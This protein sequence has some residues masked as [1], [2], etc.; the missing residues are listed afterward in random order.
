MDGLSIARERITREADEKT[1]SL[2]L[3]GL[4]LIE[5]PRELFGLQGLQRLNLG[6][7]YWD[8]EA[9]WQWTLPF[10]HNAIAAQI[11]HLAQL[12][13]LQYL[14]MSGTDLSD[15]TALKDLK[16]LQSIDC[17]RTQVSDLTPLKDL[18][19]LQSIDC[20]HTRVSDL[21]PLADLLSLQSLNCRDTQVSDL[22]PLKD[23]KNLQSINCSYTRVSSLT[24]LK[25]LSSLQSLDC[26]TARVGDLAPLK[27]L[28]SL[29]SL[30]FTRT[31]VS[32]L[33]PLKDL[34]SLRSVTC[35]VTQVS[36]LSPLKDLKSLRSVACSNTQVSDLSPLKDLKNLQSL[37]C[38]ATNVN[39]LT[40]LKD[41]KSL[42]LLD[43]LGTQVTSLTPLKGLK[44]LQSLDCSYTQI[45][46]LTPLKDVANLQSLYCSG[47]Q[48][49]DLT[50]LKDLASLE[51]LSCAGTQVSD[52]TPLKDLASLES[53]DCSGTQVNALTPLK[54]LASLQSLDCSRSQVKDLAP[55]KD[56]QSLL[57]LDCSGTQVNDLTPLTDLR[58]LQWLNCSRCRLDS[59][60]E[61]LLL[62]P[63]LTDLILYE[64]HLPRTPTEVLSQGQ[65]DNCLASLRAHLRDLEAG[66]EPMPD[67]KLMVLGNGRVG[68]TQMCRRLRNEA[69]DEGVESTHGILVTSAP[70]VPRSGA[71]HAERLQIWDFGGQDIYHGTHALFMRSRAIFALAWIPEAEKIAEHRHGG[72]VFRNQPLG[73][74]LEY[75]RH[76]GSSD[77]PVLVI[78]ARCDAPEDEHVRLPVADDALAAFRFRKVLHYSARRDRG[79]A[80]LDEVLRE[81]A[82]WLTE[83]KGIA[84]IGAG[85]S[86]VKRRLEAMRD[87]DAARGPLER[88]H[89]SISQ[90]EFRRLCDEAGG[91]ASP[92]HLLSYLHNAGAVF[93][94]EGLFGN[95]IILDQGWALEAIYAVFHREKCLRKLQRQNGRFTRSDLAEWIWDEAGYGD[96]EQELFLSMMRSCGICFHLRGAAKGRN[97]ETEYIA[98]DLLPERP[99]DEIAQKWD[100][101]LPTET[102]EFEYPSL[103]PGLMRAVISRIGD[104]AGFAADYWR[105]GVY[106][107]ESG[108]GS[109]ALI[110][111]EMAG[112]WQGRVQIRTQRGQAALLLE[113]LKALVETEQRRIGIA[114]T[115]A[116]AAARRVKPLAEPAVEPKG[117]QTAPPLKFVQEPSPRPEYFVSYA[118]DDDT[119]EGVKR[120]GI[121]DQMCAAAE[122]RGIA[123]LRDK[124]ALRLGD[125]ISKFMQRIGRGDR[126]FVVLSDKYLK[127][128]FCMFELSEV[129]RRCQEE[130]D[131]FLE[132]IRV[133]WRLKKFAH[134]VGDILATMADIV[135]PRS[136]EEF[137]SY[138][139]D[140]PDG[141]DKG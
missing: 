27:D 98:P 79:R 126:I 76:F 5:L 32:D 39:D 62:K 97:V 134:Q 4:G 50:P 44:S 80:A 119:P 40:P 104:E 141:P 29:Q 70:L 66:R 122:Q 102:A 11:E 129:W 74:W 108:T 94:R 9:R 42:Q 2:N 12:A 53:L 90:E 109:K 68:K 17:S 33:S 56:L 137:K 61:D 58:G 87:E 116:P 84:V 111:Q 93:H 26:A 106:I 83:Q 8:N 13:A 95:R 45:S 78:Q 82:D 131:V 130:D 85:R 20:S 100:P 121:V 91:I 63:C 88:R 101:S 38:W 132:R 6:T 22:T 69:Y 89:R 99:D 114:A 54:D 73:Y 46:D 3:G 23:V 47:T 115:S 139:F 1:G 52:L 127:S 81:A 21:A 96:K 107:Y 37:D 133:N 41:L 35:S 30:D 57:S 117:P 113:R 124:K 135:Q 43:C 31:E 72:F 138:G 55:L 48:V 49:S 120:A 7:G 128:P 118:W 77:C 110:E 64:T 60:S 140:P 51:S 24:P 136:F 65:L 28:T 105:N 15:L 36:D 14:F 86:R 16:S 125:R 92:E 18:T 67:V 112:P 34:K 59:I 75:V 25:D 103:P 71:G 19:R 123:I 10:G